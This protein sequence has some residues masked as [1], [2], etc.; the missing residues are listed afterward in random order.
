MK[1]A[2]FFTFFLASGWL[3]I[4]TPVPTAVTLSRAQDL[5]NDKTLAAIPELA[6]REVKEPPEPATPGSML[7]RAEEPPEPATPGI[8]LERDEEIPEPATPGSMLKRT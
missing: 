3:A 2:T 5:P 7:R 8:M 1:T 4:A 6:L